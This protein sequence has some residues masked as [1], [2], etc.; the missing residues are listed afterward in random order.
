MPP[1]QE[2]DTILG[3]EGY[4]QGAG[5][6]PGRSPGKPGARAVTSP[7][8]EG[9]I[10]HHSLEK[11]SRLGVALLVEGLSR[12]SSGETEK[13]LGMHACRC[14]ACAAQKGDTDPSHPTPSPPL[15]CSPAPPCTWGR[16][17]LAEGSAHLSIAQLS[18][19]LGTG[20][21]VC[22]NK[23]ATLQSQQN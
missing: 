14:S 11:S 12:E 10:D 21:S 17:S 2:A 22:T 20:Q 18:I 6:G 3:G 8:K 4:V 13:Q 9:G 7:K 16:G 5:S 15:R 23:L 19:P 1:F